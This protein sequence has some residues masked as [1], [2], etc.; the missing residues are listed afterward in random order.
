MVKFR[1]DGFYVDDERIP[2]Y[3]GAV[4]YWR[5]DPEKWG[6]I[7]DKV[8][9]MGFEVVTTYIPWE[10]HE[11]REGVFDFGEEGTK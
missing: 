5:L 11:I 7:L 10:I 3:S 9:E 1:Y 4:H 2:V 6:E 8:K